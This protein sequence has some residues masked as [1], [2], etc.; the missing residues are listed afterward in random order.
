MGIISDY[1]EQSRDH[2]GGLEAN[3][4]FSTPKPLIIKRS[5]CPLCGNE[6]IN[7]NEVHEHI[8]AAHRD[9]QQYVKVNDVIVNDYYYCDHI[10]CIEIIY[11]GNWVCQIYI[12]LDNKIIPI[13]QDS[14]RNKYVR[15]D[16]SKYINIKSSNMIKV[17]FIYSSS[18]SEIIIYQNEMPEINEYIIKQKLTNLQNLLSEGKTV[19]W[20]ELASFINN[21]NFNDI[22]QRYLNGFYEYYYGYFLNSKESNQ[23]Y[24]TAFFLLFPFISKTP[25]AST[26]IK[27]I[28]LRLNWIERLVDLCRYSKGSVFYHVAMFLSKIDYVPETKILFAKPSDGLLVTNDESAYMNAVIRYAGGDIGFVEEY[29]SSILIDENFIN[30]VDGN[31]KDRIYH[32]IAKNEKRKNPQNKRIIEDY[33]E[34]ILSPFFKKEA[35]AYR[36]AR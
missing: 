36:N 18:S 31:L 11:I 30:K 26:A 22:E 16:L 8:I 19:N 25:M 4:F 15:I 1:L 32:M 20:N 3:K 7:D 6:Y 14:T 24:E 34:R 17:K 5:K 29:L 21:N 12:E 13:K 2:H 23:H 28:C 10:E 9:H 27:F 33:Y 35:E